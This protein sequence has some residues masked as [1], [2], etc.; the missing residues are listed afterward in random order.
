MKDQFDA[1][2][3]GDLVVLDLHPNDLTQPEITIIKDANWYLYRHVILV[4]CE[5]ING[6]TET[7]PLDCDINLENLNPNYPIMYVHDSLKRWSR[8]DGFYT[9]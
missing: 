1:D 9:A 2:I 7:D 5:A 6:L 8:L 4:S 3:P